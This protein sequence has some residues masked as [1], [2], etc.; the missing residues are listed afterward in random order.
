MRDVMLYQHQKR[1]CTKQ[2]ILHL[3]AFSDETQKRIENNR[4]GYDEMYRPL[5][6]KNKDKMMS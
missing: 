6:P 2:R 5:R 3:F 1:S 4:E